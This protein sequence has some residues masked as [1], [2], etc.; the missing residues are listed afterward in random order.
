MSKFLL[1]IR[2]KN[3]NRVLIEYL[4]SLEKTGSRAD[5]NHRENE[6]RSISKKRMAKYGFPPA[7]FHGATCLI[8]SLN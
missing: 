7:S 5:L 6:I 2:V 8:V 3:M 4:L 1:G